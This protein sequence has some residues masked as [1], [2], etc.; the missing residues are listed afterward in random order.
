[1][2]ESFEAQIRRLSEKAVKVAVE[3]RKKAGLSNGIGRV[4]VR[5]GRDES[6]EMVV[7]KVTFEER[8]P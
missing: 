2:T 6:G 7:S 4:N 5:F 8:K 3:E 1:M